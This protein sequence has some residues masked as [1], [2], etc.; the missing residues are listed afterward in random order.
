MAVY[1]IYIYI[2]IHINVYT[3]HVHSN[4]PPD[5]IMTLRSSLSASA[6]MFSLRD[7][8]MDKDKAFLFLGLFNMILLEKETFTV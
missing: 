4:Y 6:K 2:Y 5:M 8:N 7:S 1:Y 3:V